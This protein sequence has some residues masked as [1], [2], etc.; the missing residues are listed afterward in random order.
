MSVL[1]RI[2]VGCLSV[3]L[4]VAKSGQG[5]GPHSNAA[6]LH[7]NQHCLNYLYFTDFYKFIGSLV[8]PDS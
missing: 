7:L 3:D 1:L 5:L 6:V 8:Q 4:P 2:Y